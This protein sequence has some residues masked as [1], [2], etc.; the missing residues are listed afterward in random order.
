MNKKSS[1]TIYMYI[2]ALLLFIAGI[3]YLA[4]MGFYENSVYFLNVKE[5][6]AMPSERLKAARLFGIVIA[7]TNT[8]IHGKTISFQ[9]SDKEYPS[10]TIPVEYTGIIPD[11][12]KTGA[13][14]I[15]EGTLSPEG[16]FQA[17]TLMTKCP[18]KYQK[19]DK[20]S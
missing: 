6:I 20:K 2:V 13:E 1:N 12:F 10:K 14:A 4:F 5:A 8:P 17:K 11:T 19:E 15:V 3:G 18:S 16:I 7:E 9:L